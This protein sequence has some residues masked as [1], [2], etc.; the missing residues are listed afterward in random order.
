MRIALGLAGLTV[1]A[2]LTLTTAHAGAAD[3][4]L[5]PI[6]LQ[7]RVPLAFLLSTPTGEAANTS[8]SDFIRIVS[9]RVE[10]HTNFFLQLTDPQVATDCAGRLGCVVQHLRSPYPRYMLVVSNVT[11]SGEADR[12][13]AVLVDV[14]LALEHAR[15]ASASGDDVDTIRETE[16]RI[17]AQAV[18]L[19][20]ERGQVRDAA[21]TEAF[22]ERLLVSR[23]SKVFEETDNWEPYG[24]IELVSDHA[25]AAI[26]LDG[27][28]VGA[29]RAG[30]TELRGVT[31]GLRRITVEQPGHEPWTT[32]LLVERGGRA[33]VTAS[34]VR[35]GSA[36][37]TLRTALVW[38][39]ASVA[40]AGLVVGGIAIARHDG[41]VAPVCLA[42]PGIECRSSASFE[43]FGTDV[44]APLGQPLSSGG[45]AIAPLGLGLVATG[46]VWSLGAW[47]L[48][49]DVPAWVPLAAGAVLGA[50]TYG[51]GVALDGGEP[52]PVR[53]SD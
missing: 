17:A 50:A 39:G 2:T 48:G 9:S 53:A 47:L 38:T 14:E 43:T 36:G 16:A 21:Q 24:S 40:A 8:S 32:E 26:S 22:I 12:L 13:S 46:A 34:L 45:I 29:T 44:R 35:A 27:V 10:A 52:V 1:L 31:A 25:G 19:G 51:L 15:A 23:L 30:V 33:S 20:P 7:E 37:E 5:A 42:G 11:L 41:G 18:L 49:D 6:V 28:A 4:G 3:A